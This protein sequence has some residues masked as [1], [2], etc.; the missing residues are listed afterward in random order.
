MSTAAATAA[1]L[2][3]LASRPIRL[4]V[5]GARDRG[6]ALARHAAYRVAVVR[7]RLARA[8]R[9]RQRIDAGDGNPSWHDAEW[10]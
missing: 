3:A 5:L 10:L 1:K 2:Y 9:L 4:V 7:G 8:A 6:T